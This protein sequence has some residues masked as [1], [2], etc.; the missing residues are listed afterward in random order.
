MRATSIALLALSALGASASYT[1]QSAAPV[2]DSGAAS[3]A[4][5]HSTAMLGAVDS[6]ELMPSHSVYMP[7]HLIEFIAQENQRHVQEALDR[8]QAVA[9]GGGVAPAAVTRPTQFPSTTTFMLSGKAI[10]YTQTFP[11]TPGQWPE[12]TNGAIG[13]G[14]IQGKIGTVHSS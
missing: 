3:D 7:D 4:P 5:S 9:P 11:P 14:T 13:M 1:K 8:R 2:A 12:P 10:P 6:S